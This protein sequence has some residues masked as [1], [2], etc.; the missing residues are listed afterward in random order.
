MSL[1]HSVERDRTASDTAHQLI[2]TG[3]E[4]NLS[5]SKAITSFFFFSSITVSLPYVYAPSDTDLRELCKLQTCQ[6]P[7]PRPSTDLFINL[8]Y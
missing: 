7:A 1:H 4:N 3:G 5:V 6:P 8:P 2:V